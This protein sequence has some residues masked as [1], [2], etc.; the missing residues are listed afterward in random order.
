M[1]SWEELQ[2]GPSPVYSSCWRLQKRWWYSAQ[3]VSILGGDVELVTIQK[4]VREFELWSGVIITVIMLVPQNLLCI[5]LCLGG[6]QV[7]LCSVQMLV[8]GLNE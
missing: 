8:I 7:L 4:C 5:K 1:V 3:L 6:I 2:N